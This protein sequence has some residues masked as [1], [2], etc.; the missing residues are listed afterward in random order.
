MKSNRTL[1]YIDNFDK[2]KDNKSRLLYG[3]MIDH[4]DFTLVIPVYG[5]GKYLSETLDN[6]QKQKQTKL[7]VQIIICD[8]KEYGDEENP[9]LRYF[10]NHSVD[11]LAYFLSER[12]LGQLNNFNRAFLLA[13]T[14]YVTML[15]DDDLLAS[16]YFHMID[17]V[18]PWL[19]KHPSVGMIHGN[20]E[21]FTD[22]VAVEDTNRIGIYRISK[23]DV[24]SAG[25]S[26]AGI[27]SCGYLINRKT[28]LDSG[29]FNDE[30]PSSGD[31]FVSAIMM[32]Q[33]HLVYEF[34]GKTGYYR[35][36][37]NLSLKLPICLGFIKQDYMFYEDWLN[38]GSFFRKIKMRILKN[39]IYSRNIDS[40]V[41][42]FGKINPEITVQA[43]D[44]NGSYK[45]YHRFGIFNL[46]YHFN[47]Y[48]MRLR[49]K[50]KI[51]FN[52]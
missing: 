40:K 11:N 20:F 28:F 37:D 33:K 17:R 7:R 36:G 46:L 34:S 23:N 16:N 10:E 41:A 50:I 48:L 31:A 22:D 24:S 35:V 21:V 38:S 9:F 42:Y 8:N 29:G 15:H 51:N 43:L 44:F 45:K 2:I 5:F 12:T 39:Y 1:M 47:I 49:H 6:V 52:I 13:K 32:Q 18:L 25:H 4:P 14:E 19:K 30:F 27:P 26:L 3:S